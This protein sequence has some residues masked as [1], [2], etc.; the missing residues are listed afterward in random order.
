MRYFFAIF[1]VLT[2]LCSAYPAYAQQ[3]EE[4]TLT[5]YYP[6]PYG[7]YD[8]LS[9]GSGYVAPVE[10]GNLIVEGNIGIGTETP[11]SILDISSTTSGFLPPRMTTADRDA[12]VNSPGGSII[13]NTATRTLEINNGTA[14]SPSWSA[15]GENGTAGIATDSLTVSLRATFAN[16]ITGWITPP[17]LPAGAKIDSAVMMFLGSTSPASPLNIVSYTYFNNFIEINDSRDQI[18]ITLLDASGNVY[19]YNTTATIYIHITYRV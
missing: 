8:S 16:G 15:V 4:I 12:I 1:I 2:L 17:F 19:S 7:E 18:R 6:A 10:N 5:T 9:I 14:A 3:N 13:Y 11:H